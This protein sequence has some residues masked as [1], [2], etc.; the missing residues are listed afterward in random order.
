MLC[1]VSSALLAS[2]F[3]FRYCALEGLR[4]CRSPEMAK[5]S[6]IRSTATTPESVLSLLAEFRAQI[7]NTLLFMKV[8]HHYKRCAWVSLAHTASWSMLFV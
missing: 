1:R 8:R 7:A 6:D 3:I 5:V 2:T 4:V